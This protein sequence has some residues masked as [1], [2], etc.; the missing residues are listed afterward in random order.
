[1]SVISKPLNHIDKGL[2]MTQRIQT[3]FCLSFLKKGAVI[4]ANLMPD[5][6]DE[7]GLSFSYDADDGT[8]YIINMDKN[9]QFSAERFEFVEDSGWEDVEEYSHN[10]AKQL[11]FEAGIIYPRKAN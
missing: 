6:M 5:T 9:G 7:Y 3:D 2:N 8:N 10:E 1:M 11:A 4:P